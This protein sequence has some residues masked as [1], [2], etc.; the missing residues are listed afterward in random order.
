MANVADTSQACNRTTGQ[1]DCKPY[2]T[3][4]LCDV[5]VNECSGN[6]TACNGTQHL[7]CHNLIGGY[8]CDCLRGYTME[9]DD[10]CLP[11]IL[12]ININV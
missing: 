5:D 12:A 8:M 1:C 2:W 7:G 11:G 3:G 9:D 4:E 6:S 10:T